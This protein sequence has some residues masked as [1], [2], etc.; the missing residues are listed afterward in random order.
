MCLAVL[1][2]GVSGLL[3]G[4]QLLLLKKS[5]VVKRLNS[6]DEIYFRLKDQDQFYHSY[7]R[8]IREFEFISGA[9]D[10]IAFDR[11]ERLKF[12]NPQKRYYAM[13][14]A[15]SSAAAFG[16]Y[17]L[18]KGTF[19]DTNRTSVLGLKVFSVYA[20]AGAGVLYLTSAKRVRLNGR[21]YLKGVQTDSP[22]FKE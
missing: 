21:N 11:I 16:I 20:I 12:M 13:I 5:R 22:L 14:Y 7:I 15:I 19:G 17:V 6:G 8:Y 2:V 9:G 1:I 18:N 4:Q 10:T 3:H